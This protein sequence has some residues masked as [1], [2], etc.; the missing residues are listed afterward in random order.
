MLMWLAAEEGQEPESLLF[1]LLFNLRNFHGHGIF[2]G[3]S[4]T[5][6]YSKLGHR[7][8]KSQVYH[9]RS[10]N[11]M[12]GLIGFAAETILLT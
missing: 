7:G 12:S 10:R 9:I 4:S 5:T 2:D 6:S 3:V 11:F 8:R 1:F